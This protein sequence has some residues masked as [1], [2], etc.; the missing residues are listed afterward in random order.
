VLILQRFQSPDTTADDHAE[1]ISSLQ[2]FDIDAAVVECHFRRR[3]GEL[4]KTIGPPDVL[5]VFEEWLWVEVPHF[6]GDL[7]IIPGRIERLDPPNSADPIFKVRPKRLHLIA[8][9]RDGAQASNDNSAIVH[10][11][12]DE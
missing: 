7:A 4:C 1:A 9:G 10:K 5:R 6:A 2:F 3:H 8:D 11:K 12:S